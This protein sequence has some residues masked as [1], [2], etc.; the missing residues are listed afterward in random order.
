MALINFPIKVDTTAD[1]PTAVLDPSVKSNVLDLA[2]F[3]RL[4]FTAKDQNGTTVPVYVNLS[5][6]LVAL[7][8]FQLP[9]FILVNAQ[10]T[11]DD[12]LQV[13]VT[14]EGDGGNLPPTN[15]P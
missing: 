5:K 9:P 6:S 8:K 4:Q 7:V 15:P 12:V 10:K 2:P 11:K 13:T 1:P 3:D 14:L